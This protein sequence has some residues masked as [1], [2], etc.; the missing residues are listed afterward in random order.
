MRPPC[1]PARRKAWYSIPTDAADSTWWHASRPRNGRGSPTGSRDEPS[2]F[3][4]TGSACG[5]CRTR[6]PARPSETVS[7][8]TSPVWIV[9]CGDIGLRMLRRYA[10]AGEH[11]VAI[12]RSDDGAIACEAAGG[13]AV[14]ADL[15]DVATLDTIE[16]EPRRVV[17]LAPPPREG[18]EDP[19]IRDFLARFGNRIDRIVLVST[20]GVYGDCDGEWIDEDNPAAPQT[21]RGRRRLD[22][23]RVVAAWA[24][25]TGSGYVI[26]RV[27]GIYAEDRLPLDR[28]RKRLP[29]VRESEAAF[30]NRIHAEDL[31]RICMI[32]LDSG[33]SGLVLNATDGRPTT[34][35]EYFNRVADA[36]G[37]PRPPQITLDEARA[38]LSPG[39]LTYALESRKISNRRML[40]TLSITLEY[41]DLEFTLSRLSPGD[42]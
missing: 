21:E 23:E 18:T 34:M 2:R 39:M 38:M 12:V 5:A 40:E 15:D 20:T 6:A 7:A 25:R 32:A 4:R 36:V 33:Q 31:A 28:L 37:L 17:Y 30:T 29:V 3:V 11:P 35:T 10:R 9:G 24:G 22:A 26:L 27:P 14:R 42:D 19:R 16:V 1:I 13:R 41:P 8:N